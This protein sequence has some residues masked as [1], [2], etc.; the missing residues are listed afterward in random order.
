TGQLR[1]DL[2]RHVA[3][4]AVALVVDRSQDRER[5]LDVLGD[6]LPVALL[7]RRVSCEQLAELVVVVAARRHR[8]LEDGRVRGDAAHAALDTTAQLA[9]GDPAALQVVEPRALAL[10]A[11]QV[12][13]ARHEVLREARRASA[14]STT[15]PGLMPSWSST[16][17]PGA[18]APKRSMPTLAS[19]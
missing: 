15:L 12:V 18:E 6:E 13:Q 11:E 14:W 16:T 10:L 8:L 2:D 9:A 4:E 5:V 19:A 7:D 17:P 1:V 3:V